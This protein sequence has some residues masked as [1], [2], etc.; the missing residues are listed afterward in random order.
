ML[1]Y[2]HISRSPDWGWK[3]VQNWRPRI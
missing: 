3:S 1:A 2:P